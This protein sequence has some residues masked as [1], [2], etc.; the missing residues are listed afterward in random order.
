M[1][2]N[3]K[4]YDEELDYIASA[5][6][7]RNLTQLG[8]ILLPTFPRYKDGEPQFWNG[9]VIKSD[10]SGLLS[11]L[12]FDGLSWRVHTDFKQGDGFSEIGDPIES[13]MLQYYTCRI[14]LCSA[15]DKDAADKTGKDQQTIDQ[16]REIVKEGK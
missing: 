2:N 9:D 3:M 13:N 11:L 14:R 16:L 10:K 7:Y 12:I 5:R 1:I 15:F 4:V 6:T 8:I